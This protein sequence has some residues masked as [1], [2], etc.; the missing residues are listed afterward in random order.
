MSQVSESQIAQMA[1]ALRRQASSDALGMFDDEYEHDA[2]LTGVEWG[3]RA[4]IRYLAQSILEQAT[5]Q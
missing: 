3:A 2:F 1:E 5:E 4:T